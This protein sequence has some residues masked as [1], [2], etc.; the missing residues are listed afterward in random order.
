MSR[1][2]NSHQWPQ[3]LVRGEHGGVPFDSP[4]PSLLVGRRRLPQE[5]SEKVT[6][7]FFEICSDHRQKKTRSAENQL[8][9]PPK[10]STACTH[11]AELHKVLSMNFL[12]NY[13]SGFR[14]TYL[15]Q[16]LHRASEPHE[17]LSDSLP[18]PPLQFRRDLRAA[19]TLPGLAN[20]SLEGVRLAR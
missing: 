5:Q 9:M 18:T 17:R 10:L 6:T 15:T 4:T 12:Q 19:L 13:L 8:K 1:S 14:T 2:P 20:P 16:S 11:A 7:Q 3:S